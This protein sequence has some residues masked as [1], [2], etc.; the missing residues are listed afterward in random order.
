MCVFSSYKQYM[1]WK[2]KINEHKKNIRTCNLTTQI[3]LIIFFC[4]SFRTFLCLYTSSKFFN[5][6]FFKCTY[7][8]PCMCVYS[9]VCTGAHTLFHWNFGISQFIAWLR[10]PVKNLWPLSNL[11]VCRKPALQEGEPWFAAL[12][13]SCGVNTLSVADV[14]DFKLS[15]ICQ[16][17]CEFPEYLTFGSSP[18]ARPLCSVSS[19]SRAE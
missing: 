6:K 17:A 15:E 3:A 12:A 1:L 16:M 11:M 2:I 5:F 10:V 4:R 7:P 19:S 9:Y 18:L 14:A 8:C 13:D